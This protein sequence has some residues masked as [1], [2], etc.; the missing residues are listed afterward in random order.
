MK[1]DDNLTEFSENYATLHSKFHGDSVSFF[2]D[3]TRVC[4]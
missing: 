2:I 3:V 4:S 1:S